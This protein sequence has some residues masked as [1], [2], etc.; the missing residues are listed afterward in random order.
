MEG[1]KPL[2][3]RIVQIFIAILI[4][5]VGGL[6]MFLLLAD[7][8]KENNGKDRIMPIYA[9]PDWVCDNLHGFNYLP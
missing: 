2:S 1:L 4:P 5:N 3:Y 8:I 9:P 7:K 6:L